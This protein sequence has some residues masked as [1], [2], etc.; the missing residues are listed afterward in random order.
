M[1]QS[2]LALEL[3]QLYSHLRASADPHVKAAVR[4]RIDQLLQEVLADGPDDAPPRRD[5]PDDQD[6]VLATRKR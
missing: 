1:T 2:K 3:M 4:R 5:E 6:A